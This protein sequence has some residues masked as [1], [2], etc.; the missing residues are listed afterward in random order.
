MASQ[1]WK[2]MRA[3]AGIERPADGPV[4]PWLWASSGG[5]QNLFERLPF[6]IGHGVIDVGRGVLDRQDR[7]DRGVGQLAGDLGLAQKTVQNCLVFRQ[8]GPDALQGQIPAAIGIMG[9]KNLAHAAAADAAEDRVWA[10][11][12]GERGGSV[13]VFLT[14][15]CIIRT[16]HPI[17]RRLT[18][19][20]L[21]C[22]WA[23]RRSSLPF[24][25]NELLFLLC[26]IKKSF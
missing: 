14:V 6:D 10:D 11:R 1:I 15:F 21:C 12:G 23:L 7:D 5:S 16:S 24:S 13:V 26:Q 17:F 9:Q 19:D 22:A 18:Q 20:V 25:K 2:K 8:I 4:W 3:N